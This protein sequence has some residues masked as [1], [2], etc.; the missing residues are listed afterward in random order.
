MVNYKEARWGGEARGARPV[1]REE[2]RGKR[3]A[4]AR[5]GGR[6]KRE[7]GRGA[8]GRANEE[9]DLA[10]ARWHKGT[11]AQRGREGKG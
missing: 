3:R 5:Q 10:E 2:G 6:V 8:R 7:E 1:E 11:K 9:W 4:G